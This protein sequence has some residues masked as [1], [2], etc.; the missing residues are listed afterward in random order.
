MYIYKWKSV[1]FVE[2]VYCDVLVLGK[3]YKY[4]MQEYAYFYLQKP[5]TVVEYSKRE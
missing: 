3:S 2:H 4:Y 1:K 5:K